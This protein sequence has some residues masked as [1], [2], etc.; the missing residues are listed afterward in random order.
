MYADISGNECMP[1][2]KP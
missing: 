1:N 2:S